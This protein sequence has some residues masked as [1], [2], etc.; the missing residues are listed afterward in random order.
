M[1]ECM[2]NTAVCAA[3]LVLIVAAWL[4]DIKKTYT[5]APGCVACDTRGY[6][7]LRCGGDGRG[8]GQ[9]AQRVAMF[10]LHCTRCWSTSRYLLLYTRKKQSV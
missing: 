5:V 8:P 7:V 10:E 6:L 3:A 9:K 2:K 4:R 1:Y